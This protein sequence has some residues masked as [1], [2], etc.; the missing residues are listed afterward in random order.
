[1]NFFKLGFRDMLPIVTGIVPFG[2]V[3]GTV[4]SEAQ[5]SLFQTV[6]MNVLVFAGASQLAA[7]ELM[8][9]NA[10]HLVVLITGLII[11]MR[12]LLY[13]AALSPVVQRSSFLVKITTAYLLTDQNYAVMSAKHEKFKSNSDSIQFYFG[14][15]L[16]MLITWHSAVI[17]GYFFGNFAP[18]AWALDYAV[19]LSF[20]ALLIP[21]LKNSKY[22]LVTLFS[23]IVSLLLYPLAY[24]MGLIIT[25]LLSIAFSAYLIRKKTA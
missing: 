14:A 8:T 12:F 16:C 18:T 7:V 21:T 22:I 15:S 19:P 1:M 11:N 25:A 5:L 2:A 20:L 6:S 24:R 3:M 4:C 10:A 23:A 9:Q 13:S 17:A